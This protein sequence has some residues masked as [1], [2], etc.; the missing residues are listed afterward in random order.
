MPDWLLTAILAAVPGLIGAGGIWVRV[1]RVER[2]VE[3]SG[4][5]ISATHERVRALEISN[6]VN[7]N[8]IAGVEALLEKIETKLETIERLIIDRRETTSPG[9][10]V[11]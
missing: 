10:R 4:R 11:R 2:D 6:A 9:T 3:E 8:S 1:S 7:V 5:I